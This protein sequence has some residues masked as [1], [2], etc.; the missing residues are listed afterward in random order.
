MFGLDQHHNLHEIGR[1]L[2]A[3]ARVL[4]RDTQAAEDLYQDALV[5]AMSA[6]NVPAGSAQF[7]MW[8]FRLLRN[9]WI[10]GV[11][12]RNRRDRLLADVEGLNTPASGQPGEEAV[13]NRLAVREAFMQ[14]SK[15]HRDVLA[16]VDIGG[17]SYDETA[18]LLGLPRGTVMSRVSRA[19]AALAE[20]L[21]DSKVVAFPLR[22]G[23]RA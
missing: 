18:E 22:R 10:D 15:E 19:R 5:R 8:M 7:R 13:V 23:R 6:S 21:D 14:L 20:R 3:Y 9:L 16:L 17:F 1:K 11:R 4:C 2:F 12:A